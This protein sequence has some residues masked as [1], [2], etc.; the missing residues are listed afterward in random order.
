MGV[1]VILAGL[2]SVS[3]SRVFNDLKNYLRKYIKIINLVRI[4]IGGLTKGFRSWQSLDIAFFFM[5]YS[6]LVSKQIFIIKK[7][8]TNAQIKF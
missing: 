7:V 4:Q 3:Y 8:Q 5:N 6:L 1:V 2:Q